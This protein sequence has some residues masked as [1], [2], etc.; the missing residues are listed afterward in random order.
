MR[1]YTISYLLSRQPKSLKKNS[2][3]STLINYFNGSP[4]LKKATFNRICFRVLN[5]AKVLP[6]N[7]NTFYRI[8]NLPKNPFFPL[9]F[10]IKSDYLYSRLE[11]NEGRKKYIIDKWNSLPNNILRFFKQLKNI[12]KLYNI[13]GRYPF[14]KKHIIPNTKKKANQYHS[15]F[16]TDWVNYFDSYLNNLK[17]YYKI[18]NKKYGQKMIA[19]FLLDLSENN[20]SKELINKQYRKF[21][22]LYHPDK[23]GAANEFRTIK[24]AR[25]FLLK[26]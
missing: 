25:D 2:H 10:K 23:G 12:E 4:E 17:R 7:L 8:Y 26:I 18:S 5:R 22:K 13:K 11:Y 19:C 16:F 1:K 21:S 9:F 14:W 6:K 20:I 24:W 15:F 3:Y